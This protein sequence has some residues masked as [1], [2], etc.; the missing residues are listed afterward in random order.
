MKIKWQAQSATQH[1]T[2]SEW[3]S[4]NRVPLWESFS[5]IVS[6]SLSV[7]VLFRAR[8]NLVHCRSLSISFYSFQRATSSQQFRCRQNVHIK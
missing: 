8:I 5:E 7:R 4:V 6:H 1:N 3:C 2:T